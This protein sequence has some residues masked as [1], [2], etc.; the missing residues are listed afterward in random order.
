[1]NNNRVEEY[2]A[3]LSPIERQ[4]LEIARDHLGSAF[5]LEK[6]NGYIKFVAAN[7]LPLPPK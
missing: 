5:S 3:S 2:L 6:S 7:P 4:G 1:M